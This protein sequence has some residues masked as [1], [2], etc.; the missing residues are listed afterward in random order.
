MIKKA[1]FRKVEDLAVQRGKFLKFF[2]SDGMDSF[3]IQIQN[4][5]DSG[6]VLLK[7]P[8]KSLLMFFF[9]SNVCPYDLLSEWE[10]AFSYSGRQR[11]HST[12]CFLAG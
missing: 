2:C 12:H 1:G 5:V 6:G 10:T 7:K 11:S 3:V 9:Y 8:L 4:A